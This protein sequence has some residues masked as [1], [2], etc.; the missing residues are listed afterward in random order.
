M[1]VAQRCLSISELAEAVAAASINETLFGWNPWF[2]AGIRLGNVVVLA[3]TCRSVFYACIPIIWRRLT[4]MDDLLKCLPAHL[5]TLVPMKTKRGDKFLQLVSK[6]SINSKLIS[7]LASILIFVSFFS[8][9]YSRILK[10][11]TGIATTYTLN[12]SELYTYTSV[13]PHDIQALVCGKLFRG[14]EALEPSCLPFLSLYGGIRRTPLT[15]KPRRRTCSHSL[16][17][18]SPHSTS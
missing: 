2:D 8:S 3:R 18:P 12:T 10:V 7:T 11:P 9:D 15:R 16:H 5:W 17:P 14:L 4:T 13:N 6:A 1:S